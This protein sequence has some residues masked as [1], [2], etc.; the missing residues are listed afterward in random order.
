M[1]KGRRTDEI[2]IKNGGKKKII[3][4]QEKNVIEMSRFKET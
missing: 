1:L 3:T 4:K 2:E